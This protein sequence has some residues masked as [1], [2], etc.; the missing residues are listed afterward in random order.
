MIELYIF[1]IIIAALLVYLL[2]VTVPLR[3]MFF[4]FYDKQNKEQDKADRRFADEQDKTN[5]RWAL[6]VADLQAREMNIQRVFNDSLK[7]VIANENYIYNTVCSISDN[8]MTKQQIINSWNS[9]H[10][11][12]DWSYDGIYEQ[13]DHCRKKLDRIETK[14]ERDKRRRS[15]R[16]E[17]K[18]TGCSGRYFR[19]L[20]M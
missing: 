14:L 1:D 16:T 19:R 2:A 8:L 7:T 15:R 12:V 11:H 17:I 13:F 9:I 18:T 20:A 6:L 5:K 10:A 3:A 4:E